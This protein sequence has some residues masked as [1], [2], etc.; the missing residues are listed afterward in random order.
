MKKITIVVLLFAAAA[1]VAKLG[2]ATNGMLMEGYG[3]ISTAMGGA[4]MAYDNGAGLMTMVRGVWP[5][6]RQRWV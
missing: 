5:I 1:M 4:Y 6:T 3:P 2:H